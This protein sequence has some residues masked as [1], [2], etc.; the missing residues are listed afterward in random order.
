MTCLRYNNYTITNI[1]ASRA[2]T[3]F[4]LIIVIILISGVLYYSNAT[5]VLNKYY[6]NYRSIHVSRKISSLTNFAKN[7]A[8][9]ANREVR[10]CPSQMLSHEKIICEEDWHHP[11][12]IFYPANNNILSTHEQLITKQENILYKPFVKNKYLTFDSQGN[13]TATNATIIYQNMY[14]TKKIII[15][16]IGRSR[17]T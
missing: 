8:L 7:A 1:L 9:I 3:L 10:L 11:I 12:I 6:Y 16:K 5:F 2:F 13:N 15:N 14:Y 17:I 4:E